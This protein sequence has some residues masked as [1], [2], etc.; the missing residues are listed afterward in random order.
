MADIG[1]SDVALNIPINAVLDGFNSAMEGV[2]SSVSGAMD[3]VKSKMGEVREAFGAVGLLAGNALKD[4]VEAAAKAQQNFADLQATV[5]STGGAAGYTAEQIKAMA[6]ELSDKTTFTSGEIMK[7]QNML[8]TFTNISGQV[9]KDASMAMLDLSQKM[10]TAPQQTAIQ[11]GKA[12][13]DPVKGITALTRVGVT[14]T[15]QQK[16]Q[17]A[18]MEASNNMAGAQEV[19]I[20]ELNKEFGGQAAAQLNTYNGQL[21]L[22]QNNMN[23]MK[24]AIGN[25]VLPY[26]QKMMQEINKGIEPIINFIKAHANMVAAILATTT[27]IGTLIGGFAL[28]TKVS[29]ILGP[30]V[31]GITELIGSLSL[32]V[33]G[34][35]AA[36]GLLVAAYVTNFN[37]LKTF[38]DGIIG[39]LKNVLD[40]VKGLF[41]TFEDDLKSGLSVVA[42]IQDVISKAFGTQVGDEVGNTIA[43]IVNN[44][45]ILKDNV[46]EI[47]S[48]V[49]DIVKDFINL[50]RVNMPTIESVMRTT[51]SIIS[52]VVTS[53]LIPVF[54]NIIGIVGQVVSFIKNN[55]NTIGTIITGVFKIVSITY[56]NVFAPVIN[57][58]IQI[59]GSLLNFITSNKVVIDGILTVFMARM[60]MLGTQAVLN[61]AKVITY[62]VGSLITTGKE[63]I[64]QAVK[65]TTFIASMVKTGAEAVING[66]KVVASFIGGMIKAGT[67]AVISGAKV[68]SSFVASL[69]TTGTQAVI[70][71]AKIVGSFIASMATAGVQAAINGGKI[72]A[73]FVAAIIASGAQSVLSAAKIVGSFV[74]S[75]IVAST[76]SVLAAAR[77]GLVTAAQWLLNAAMDANPIGLVI[78]AIGALIAAGVALYENWGTVSKKAGEA[79]QAIKNAF[80][81]LANFGKEAFQWGKDMLDQ[82]INGIKSSPIGQACEE[83]ASTVRSFLHF[84]VPD[85]GPLSDAD[86]YG[87]DFMQLIAQGINTNKFKVVDA[88]KGLATNMSVGIKAMP[89]LNNLQQSTKPQPIPQANINKDTNINIALDGTALA[90]A[91]LKYTEL[92]QG[93]N[94]KFVARRYG[95]TNG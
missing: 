54:R 94:N 38:I 6:G 68:V 57:K 10:G 81:P 24:A 33:A 35:I 41:N 21:K 3:G 55:W 28:F 7:G 93:R 61:G 22:L 73:S 19:I 11:L 52:T 42:S 76:Q 70:N 1:G 90:K 64:A 80:E 12:L 15:E 20:K 25:A 17:I 63:A 48:N 32:P 58:L 4:S 13:N 74:A 85:V 27:A 43:I 71:G 37:G 8:L 49:I 92:T 2:K 95:V 9:Y 78:L 87:G 16:Q 14:F 46:K 66:G 5:K 62:F 72:V 59:I 29:S 75:L 45:N 77:I 26:L 60:A 67:Q 53:V 82:F 40:T 83:V 30:A 31:S 51:F 91:Q 34:I 23:E 47:F 56:S 79:W 89:V 18:T 39:N 86:T 50:V 44:F 84:S 88:V 36:I 65:I 69:V